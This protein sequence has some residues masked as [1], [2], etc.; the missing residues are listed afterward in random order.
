[1]TLTGTVGLMSFIDFWSNVKFMC[2][3]GVKVLVRSDELN[4]ST[5][6]K[7]L[8]AL[9]GRNG[10]N[11][12]TGTIDNNAFYLFDSIAGSIVAIRSVFAKYSRIIIIITEVR[13]Y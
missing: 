8:D 7:T 6:F 13:K 4:C 1:M 2:F 12:S 10:F 5:W 11:A 3:N 9:Y